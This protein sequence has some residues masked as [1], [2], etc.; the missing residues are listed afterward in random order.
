MLLRNNEY[1]C[2]VMALIRYKAYYDGQPLTE[3]WTGLGTK[4]EF[5]QALKAGYM[6]PLTAIPRAAN[7]SR[8]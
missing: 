1:Q 3:A 5:K 7:W 2:L 8:P 6:R 4:T